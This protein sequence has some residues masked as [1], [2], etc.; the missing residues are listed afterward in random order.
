MSQKASKYVSVGLRDSKN[1]LKEN[2]EQTLKFNVF[3][4]SSLLAKRFFLSFPLFALA[5][6]NLANQLRAN[7]NMDMDTAFED[8]EDRGKYSAAAQ[9]ALLTQTIFITGVLIL[10]GLAYGFI[11]LGF[12]MDRFFEF[13]RYYTAF[14][15]QILSGGVF[16]AFILKLNTYFGP[17]VYMIQ[18]GEAKGL[19]DA[20]RQGARYMS[21]TGRVKL[22]YIHV[23]HLGRFLVYAIVAFLLIYG[24][25]SILSVFSAIATTIAVG[26][27]FL[28]AMPRVMLSHR[29]STTHL[30]SDLI[31]ENVYESL[32]VKENTEGTNA[33]ISK[34]Q[35][36]M[37]L[38]DE[39][40]NDEDTEASDMERLAHE[41]G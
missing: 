4:L 1:A 7:K 23:Y 13:D 10:G 35:T 29:I 19:Q 38:F 17:A 12:I 18:S 5:E 22:T 36:L 41:R 14:I 3:S 16:I 25:F 6:Y 15:F 30:L 33:S 24:A 9:L 27:V 31:T 2:R 32:L 39:L 21:K 40:S 20:L 11:H 26:I 8:S 28:M 34:E 37:A